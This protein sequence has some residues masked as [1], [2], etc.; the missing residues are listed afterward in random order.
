MACVLL[1]LAPA[2][3]SAQE[4]PPPPDVATIS[5]VIDERQAELEAEQAAAVEADLSSTQPVARDDQAD[6]SDLDHE[7]QVGIR[8]GAGVPFVFALR[9]G[10]GA[11]CDGGGNA[12]CVF[13]G[14]GIV[15][16]ELSFGVT[17]DLE[18]TAMFRIG[19][20]GQEPTEQ[21]NMMAGLGIRSYISPE[22]LFKFFLGAR[23]I[24]DFTQNGGVADWGDVDFGVR[25][26]AGVQLDIV[27]WV[28]LY[29]QLGVN[30]TFLRAFG[31]SPDLTGG[32]QV[33]FP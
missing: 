30:V 26:E 27:R 10:D 3:V 11:P 32:V 7:F 15:D 6:D 16:T 31:I 24:L 17:R 4:E 18:I 21:N 2:I 33:R 29:I 5:V 14:S 22:S 1:A 25:G 20:I 19:M 8:A 12:F 13:V 23:F 9:Y 28:G